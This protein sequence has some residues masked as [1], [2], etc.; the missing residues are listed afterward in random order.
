MLRHQPSIHARKKGRHDLA[1]L[2]VAFLQYLGISDEYL[3]VLRQSSYAVCAVIEQVKLLSI[4]NELV[5]QL[6]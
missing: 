5:I 2:R 6:E 4:C 3:H 1:N